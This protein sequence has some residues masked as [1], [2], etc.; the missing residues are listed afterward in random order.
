M[1]C[2]YSI[3]CISIVDGAGA[4]LSVV[5]RFCAAVILS[6]N[7]EVVTNSQGKIVQVPPSCRL[8]SGSDDGT[9]LGSDR[10]KVSK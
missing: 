8:V 9:L 4:P 5:D 1:F 7:N 3:G 10:K 6:P 2:V